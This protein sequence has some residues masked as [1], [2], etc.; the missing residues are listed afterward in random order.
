MRNRIRTTHEAEGGVDLPAHGEACSATSLMPLE[1]IQPII[2]LIPAPSVRR[3][4][5][6][7]VRIVKCRPATEL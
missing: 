1:E 7:P 6:S 3:E 5:D 2:Q 4:W